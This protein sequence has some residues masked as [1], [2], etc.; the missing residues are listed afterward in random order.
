MTRVVLFA[1]CIFTF[2]F[3][4]AQLP[5]YL[6]TNGLAGWWPFNGNANDESGNGNNGVVNGAAL[7]IDRFGN[8]GKAFEFDGLDDNVL[9]QNSSSLMILGDITMSAWVNTKGYDQIHNY[10]TIISKR[11]QDYEWQYAIVSIPKKQTV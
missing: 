6:P 3:A 7:T 5:T 10:Q 8:V 9:V 4:Q 1:F 11:Q 2:E